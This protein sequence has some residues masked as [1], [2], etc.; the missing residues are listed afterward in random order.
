MDNEVKNDNDLPKGIKKTFLEKNIFV[1]K[2][3]S[4]FGASLLQALH[5]QEKDIR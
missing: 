4:P 1:L 3:Y 5:S 2:S